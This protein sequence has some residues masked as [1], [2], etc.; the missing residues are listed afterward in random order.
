MSKAQSWL[1]CLTTTLCVHRLLLPI[2]HD[3]GAHA[4]QLRGFGSFYDDGALQRPAQGD[5]REA[6][7]GTPVHWCLHGPQYCPEQPVPR[8]DYT[9]SQSSHQVQCHN[10]FK[11]PRTQVIG[12]RSAL[13][14][15]HPHTL[16]LTRQQLTSMMR[17]DQGLP[18]VHIECTPVDLPMC[19]GCQYPGPPFQ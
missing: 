14:V 15:P 1:Q 7:E 9:L 17:P 4:L 11:L 2:V 6:V 8:G 13:D 18:K 12:S 3:C 19:C 10:P 5:F 16:H